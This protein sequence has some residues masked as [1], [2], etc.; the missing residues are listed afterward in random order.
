MQQVSSAK[1][2]LKVTGNKTMIKAE[3]RINR[4]LPAE[5]INLMNKCGERKRN[6]KTIIKALRD[7]LFMV[8]LYINDE[9]VAFGRLSGDGAMYF[10]ITDV[11]VDPAY[12]G[13][14]AD[15]Q[16]YKEIDD[17]LL[18]VAPNDSRI[19]VM[20]NKKYESIFRTFGYEYMDPDY[21]KVMIRE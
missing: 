16:L 2:T 12:E 18:A 17:F 4:T 14:G 7:G 13:S 5:L 10:L 3:V 11:M 8:G 1:V 15:M 21:R 9:L 19:L 20:T 6:P